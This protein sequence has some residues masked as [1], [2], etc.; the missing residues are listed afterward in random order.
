M[1]ITKSL[2][3]WR[4]LMDQL[5]KIWLEAQ[6]LQRQ[7]LTVEEQE[8]VEKVDSYEH[9]CEKL[10][11]I[12]AQYKLERW[13]RLLARMDPFVSRLRSF[14]TVLS[15]F[16]QAK[17]EV[18]SFVWGSVALV[19]ELA[20]GH[21][22]VLES[23]VDTFEQMER[24]L[25]RFQCYVKEYVS[26]SSTI[27]H[28]RD[29]IRRYYQELIDQCQDY[30]RFLKA[31]S[32]KNF[33]LLGR[34][35]R[36]LRT[37]STRRLKRLRHLSIDV[38]QEA[39]IEEHRITYR[40]LN[41]LR[42]EPT[43]ATILP[44]HGVTYRQNPAFYSRPQYLEQISAV[45]DPDTPR[46]LT[47]FALVGFGGCGKTQLAIEYT[48]RTNHY[49]AILWCA[50]ENSLQLSESFAM[51]ARRLDLIKG[52][53]VPQK[54][55]CIGKPSR[56][57]MIFDNMEPFD[58]L[59]SF[60][61]SGLSGSILVTTRNKTLAKEF[62]ESQVSI[63]PFEPL[64]ARRFL[65]Q[66]RTSGTEH[67]CQEDNAAEII[68]QRLGNL[69]LALDLVRHHV[70]ASG[71]SYNEFLKCY[72]EP[73]EPFLYD[74]ISSTWRNEWYHQNVFATYTLGMQRMTNKAVDMIHVLAILDVSCIPLSIF[75]ANKE[76]MLYN[77]PDVEDELP[78]LQDLLES[79]V[80]N[81]YELDTVVSEL[82]DGSLIDRNVGSG[83][84]SLHRI[85]QDSVAYSFDAATRSRSFG[86]VL[87]YLNGCFPAQRDGALEYDSHTEGHGLRWALK[88][89]SIRQELC[90][91]LDLESDK[92]MLQVFQ[93]NIALDMLANGQLREALPLL[94]AVHEY[95]AST[96][97]VNADNFYRTLS[98]S[99]CYRLLGKYI[100]AMDCSNIVM[101]VIQEHIG[102]DS[103][104]MAT[105]RFCWGNLLLCMEDRVGAYNA[106]SMCF[107]TR[108]KLMPAHFDTA[109]A[110]HKLGAMA[111]Q[112][113]D[114]GASIQLLTQALQIL[115]DTDPMSLAAIRTAYLL[116]T[117]L[118]QSNQSD[119]AKLMRDRVN[120][121]LEAEGKRVDAEEAGY[122][123]SFFDS[124]VL[125][126]H[127]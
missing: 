68:S 92:C 126:R 120:Q 124:L 82:M 123:Q 35:S 112:N 62:T 40:T 97:G 96:S 53:D 106:F 117:A 12:Q 41:S 85:L 65:L 79:P 4:V 55:L 44:Y 20:A 56:W 19:L 28:L 66:Y 77:G 99:I 52:D 67:T 7:H 37:G 57:L 31:S 87:F 49:D 127:L 21:S 5:T 13:V 22:A 33:L 101:K 70:S 119:A 75:G 110:A 25:P 54:D 3:A 88:A 98:L 42:V 51:H 2:V 14:A 125:F 102:E 109:F 115:G 113:G 30:I 116:S 39:R 121:A 100:H 64:D 6:V 94:E 27:T 118:L 26:P 90:L 61:P 89:R 91:T 32:L 80:A 78:Q 29:A 17:P 74:R 1:C 48:H 23:I 111:V 47:S 114:L 93:H 69:P 63:P 59:S 84:L 46:G 105:A 73:S 95:D 8:T 36:K 83:S 86:K 24:V 38:E 10:G 34:T 16:A 58:G 18:L 11:K 76:E 107:L 81:T 72:G 104:P 108:Q 103:V 122:S 60:W 43:M 45:L 71:S 15:V 50:A 9:L